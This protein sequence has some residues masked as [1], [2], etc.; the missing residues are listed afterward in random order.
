[1]LFAVLFTDKPG[2]GHLRTANLDAHIR[3]VEGHGDMVLVAGSLR[4]EP[5]MVPKGGLWIV[6]A[7]SKEA[8]M[9]LM[10]T[11]PFYTC[12]LR[13][14]VEVLHWSKALDRKVPV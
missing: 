4:V 6:E 12:G 14:Q 11:D 7:P 13:E 5:G 8:V 9:E 3:W 1:M 10:E 2:R